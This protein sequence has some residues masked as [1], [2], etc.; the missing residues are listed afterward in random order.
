VELLTRIGVAGWKIASGE[1][2]N[3]LMFERMAATRLP[4][5]L[6]TG[7][8]PI[9]EIDE[10][11]NRVQ[12]YM[13]PLAVLQCTSAY[14]C[15]PEKV[16]LNL[17]PFFRGRYHCAVGPSDH[18]GTMYPGLA[19]TMMGIEVLEVHVTL[20]R[21]MFGPDVAVSLT[22]AELRQLVEGVR[23]IE[24]RMDHPV[25]KDALAEESALMRA[26]FTKSVVPRADLAAGTVLQPE[27]LTAK[28][29]GTGI[30]AARL[31]QL[32]GLR[33][34]RSI[35]ADELLQEEDLE[36]CT[37]AAQGVCSSHGPAQL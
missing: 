18:S 26:L 27:H 37:D 11:V 2:G 34:K 35:K 22:T 36:V 3:T 14:P 21:E 7:M 4:V 17:V 16:G 12:S 29:P 1:V 28:K 6:S 25:D 10:A 9:S 13:L 8:S 15:P 32:L 23:F 19:A 31:P 30:P 5:L 33:L 24:R 20:S